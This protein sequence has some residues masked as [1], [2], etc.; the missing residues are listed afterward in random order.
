MHELIQ[1]Y[2]DAIYDSLDSDVKQSIFAK[3]NEIYGELYYYSVVKLL[4]YL[5][6]TEKD[7]FLDIG[8]GLGKLVFQLFLTTQASA[9]T[10]IEIN[11]ARYEIS[12]KIKKMLEQQFPETFTQE[13]SLNLIHGDFLQC[14]VTRSD[15]NDI[16]IAYI[17]GTVFSFPLLTAIGEK[18]NTMNSVEKVVSL[19]KLPNMN[20][21]MLTKRIFLHGSWDKTACYIYNRV[22]SSA[23]LNTIAQETHSQETN[24]Q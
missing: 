11:Y 18:I 24:T 6:I 20:H 13:R 16:T 1:T 12:L 2:F 7:H 4:N 22:K 5:N 17:C 21:F 8:S 23:T 9:V 15:F 10:G 14:D 3:E 19:R